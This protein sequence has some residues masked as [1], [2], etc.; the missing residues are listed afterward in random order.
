MPDRYQWFEVPPPPIGE[1]ISE[2]SGGRIRKRGHHEYA[3][4]LESEIDTAR[5]VMVARHFDT[6]MQHFEIMMAEAERHG[7][8]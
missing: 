2:P 1:M 8:T 3:L 5:P 4:Y 6:L 7:E